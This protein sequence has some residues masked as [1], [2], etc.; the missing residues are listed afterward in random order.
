MMVIGIVMSWKY[1][2]QLSSLLVWLKVSLRQ[3]VASIISDWV[4]FY[5]Y[6]EGK[7]KVEICSAM[8]VEA[9]QVLR[10]IL[11]LCVRSS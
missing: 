2:S 6:V 3:V 11:V 1:F 5:S 10:S 9:E 8:S 7:A 4:M